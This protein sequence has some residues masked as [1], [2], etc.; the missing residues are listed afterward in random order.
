ML[1]EA[2]SFRHGSQCEQVVFIHILDERVQFVDKNR[3]GYV[4]IKEILR[5]NAQVLAD[6]QKFGQGGQRSP[7]R[8]ALDIAFA[9]SKIQAHSVFGNPFLDSQK[10]NSISDELFIHMIHLCVQFIQF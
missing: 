10:C 6:I 5:R 9:V 1:M 4:R 8:N 3:F 7:G 2:H